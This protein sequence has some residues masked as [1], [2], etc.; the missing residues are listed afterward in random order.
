MMDLTLK[1]NKKF[2]SEFAKY[3]YELALWLALDPAF[4]KHLYSLD[5]ISLLK[6]VTLFC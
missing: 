4:F 3:N 2:N 5:N 1:P 6:F